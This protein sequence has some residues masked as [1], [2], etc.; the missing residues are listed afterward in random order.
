[1]FTGKMFN[2]T[3]VLGKALEGTW[4]RNNAIS[5]NIANVDTPGYKRKDVM[6]EGY[7]QRAL[8]SENKLSTNELEKITPKTVF[9]Q[10]NTSYR[11]DGNN[12]DIDAEMG[13]LA[14]NQ[15]KYTAL[16]SQV[17]YGFSRLKKVLNG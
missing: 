6:F 9:G 5:T 17:N 2:T 8:M 12:V 13:Y 14:E 4:A 1:M 3:D 10:S 15:L 16:I 11:I 7:L